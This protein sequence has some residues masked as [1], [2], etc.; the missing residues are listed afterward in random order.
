MPCHF[1]CHWIGTD[2]VVF[3][4]SLFSVLCCL[5]ACCT[6]LEMRLIGNWGHPTP[7]TPFSFVFGVCGRRN[8]TF[9]NR[10]VSP[11]FVC[12]KSISQF[13]ANLCL[14]NLFPAAESKKEMQME[15]KTETG[16][17][18]FVSWP[19]FGVLVRFSV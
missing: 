7:L 18:T 13:D 10:P 16:V 6:Q 11:K 2:I 19:F 4:C 1:P 15:L 3:L 9:P 12:R 14:D 5:M 8:V 17:S